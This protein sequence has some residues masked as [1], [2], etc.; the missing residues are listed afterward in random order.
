MLCA[1]CYYLHNLKNTKNTHG[2]VSFSIV[3]LQVS[4][5]SFTKSNTPSQVFCM[6]FKLYKWYQIAQNASCNNK[7]LM[8]TFCKKKL[9]SY[10]TI[11]TETNHIHVKTE[12]TFNWNK[13]IV[14]INLNF[15]KIYLDHLFL[16]E[17]VRK[18]ATSRHKIS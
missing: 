11:I 9:R 18:T 4:V 7:N 6:F 10:R 15:R 2:G 14:K 1:I 8:P 17:Y 16:K 13:K 12:L 5:C 3:K